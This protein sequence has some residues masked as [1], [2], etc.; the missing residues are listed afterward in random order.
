MNR[1][2]DEMASRIQTAII[3]FGTRWG[4]PPTEILVNT[5]DN[6]YDIKEV[7]GIEIRNWSGVHEGLII[8]RAPNPSDFGWW[9]LVGEL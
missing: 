8:C 1:H 3:S 4:R 7:N 9:T 6:L 5:L 2:A